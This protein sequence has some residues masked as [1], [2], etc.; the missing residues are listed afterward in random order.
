MELCSV[1][2]GHQDGRGVWGRMGVC[3]RMA[4]SLCCSPGTVRT[5]L[6]GYMAIQSEKFKKEAYWGLAC[7][8]SFHPSRIFP[9][10]F[11]G[12]TEFLMG[13][14]CSETAQ[15]SSYHQAGLMVS[16]S[17]SLA[18]ILK[19][20]FILQIMDFGVVFTLGLK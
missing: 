13:T 19:K 6:V 5:L 17:G 14:S 8:P 16:V 4:Q 2:C 10:S 12:G 7:P 3:V 9:V 1:V 18:H 11:P 20:K 15:A